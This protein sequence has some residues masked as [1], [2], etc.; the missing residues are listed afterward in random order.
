MYLNSL[1]L[2][3]SKQVKQWQTI[4]MGSDS[5]PEHEPK[6]FCVIRA[7]TKYQNYVVENILLK[8]IVQLLQTGITFSSNSGKGPSNRK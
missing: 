5:F 8:F 2:Q 3:L 7:R 1:L 4:E 6:K